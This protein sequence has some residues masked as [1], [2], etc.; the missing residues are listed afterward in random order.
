MTGKRAEKSLKGGEKKR[1]NNNNLKARSKQA[2]KERDRASQ[3]VSDSRHLLSAIRTRTRRRRR[4][5]RRHDTCPSPLAPP[6]PLF[7]GRE[8][9]IWMYLARKVC[10]SVYIKRER[11]RD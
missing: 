9:T 2:S 10:E 7:L 8:L 11:E 5:R 4:R 3:G 6:S 1:V